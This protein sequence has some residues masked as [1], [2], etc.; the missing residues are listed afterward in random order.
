M[1]EQRAAEPVRANIEI[2]ER[3]RRICRD[4]DVRLLINDLL[5]WR[6]VPVFLEGGKIHRITYADILDKLEPLNE[7]RDDSDRITYCSLWIHAK[8]HYDMAAVAAYWGARVNR[9]FR[10]ALRR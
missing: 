3:R 10:S 8:R 1:K 4:P 2:R 7:G 6:G 5:D 9:E